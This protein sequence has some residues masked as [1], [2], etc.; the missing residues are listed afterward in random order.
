MII[1]NKK[2]LEATGERY[3][4]QLRG[5]IA[6]EHLHRYAY[7]C[8]FVQGKVVLDIASGEGYGSEM[9]SRTA[10]HVYG[11]DIDKKSVVHAAEKY[12]KDNLEFILGS[13][14]KIPLP[15]HSVDLVVSF[16]TIEHTKQH[17]AMLQEI[18]RVLKTDGFLIISSPEKADYREK[19]N[20]KNPFHLHELDLEEFQR[21]LLKHFPL[22]S[23][24]GQRIISGSQIYKFEQDINPVEAYEL[25]RLPNLTEKSAS[26]LRP[27]YILGICGKTA[28]SSAFG[29]FCIQ[30]PWETDY[31]LELNKQIGER[32]IRILGLKRAIASIKNSLIWR[33]SWPIRIV[34]FKINR[35]F[36][37][38]FK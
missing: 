25:A 34:H 3:V 20:E 38:I 31:C 8:E 12:Q 36:R 32:D 30:R 9:L 19:R 18:K 28:A 21:L 37:L 14:E 23:F 29:S 27:T 1:N 35:F 13:C 10:L 17:D 22:C 15:D 7:A 26:D 4:P 33:L 11:V 16:E 2:E 24:F 6:L 5:T